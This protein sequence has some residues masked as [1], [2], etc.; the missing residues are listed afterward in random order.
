MHIATCKGKIFATP[1]KNKKEDIMINKDRFDIND[2]LS[3]LW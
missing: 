2:S 3:Q 1:N